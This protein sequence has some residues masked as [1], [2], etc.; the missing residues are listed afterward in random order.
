MIEDNQRAEREAAL[1][2]EKLRAR[3]LKGQ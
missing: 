2:S 3:A 1:E